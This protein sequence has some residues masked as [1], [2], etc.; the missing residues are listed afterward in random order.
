MRQRVRYKLIK[1]S[2]DAHYRWLH[3]P[4]DEQKRLLE[5]L[6]P[7]FVVELEPLRDDGHWG[8]TCEAR[9]VPFALGLQQ[10]QLCLYLTRSQ[11][12]D[13]REQRVRYKVNYEPNT[14]HWE[15]GSQVLHDADAKKPEMLMEVIGYNNKGWCRTRYVSASRRDRRRTYLNS[16]SVLH[17]P[18]LFGVEVSK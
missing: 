17:D 3:V 2:N 5:A 14:R 11:I 12:P 1:R 10:K 4:A 13:S 16:V 18:A 9:V 8:Y 6:K 7:G 15:L